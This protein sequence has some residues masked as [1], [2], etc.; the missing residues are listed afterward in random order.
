[1]EAIALTAI[2][3]GVMWAGLSLSYGLILVLRK[4]YDFWLWYRLRRNYRKLY[5]F[6]GR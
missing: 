6:I 1:M 3:S 4:C 2:V 5:W